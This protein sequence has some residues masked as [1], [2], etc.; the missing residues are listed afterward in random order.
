M[1][2]FTIKVNGKKKLILGKTV[3]SKATIKPQ[4]RFLMAILNTV[5]LESNR[6]IRISRRIF[7]LP[8]MC[9]DMPK[10]HG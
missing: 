6:K 5:S 2:A 8:L 1:I 4:K 3:V 9:F 7:T 10:H